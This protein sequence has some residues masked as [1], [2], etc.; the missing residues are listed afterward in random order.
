MILSDFDYLKKLAL[1]ELW[2]LDYG[3]LLMIRTCGSADRHESTQRVRA[4]QP[5]H[6]I[7]ALTEVLTGKNSAFELI[8]PREHSEKSKRERES[9]EKM[10]IKN[11]SHLKA[12]LLE[13]KLPRIRLD[14]TTTTRPSL[15][16]PQT[17]SPLRVSPSSPLFFNNSSSTFEPIKETKKETELQDSDSRT[18]KRIKREGCNQ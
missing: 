8:Q 12:A 4:G 15:Q 18:H 13:Q 2:N 3:R 1:F 5:L 14:Q 16:L 9:R 10:E 7:R 11:R 17:H 6:R